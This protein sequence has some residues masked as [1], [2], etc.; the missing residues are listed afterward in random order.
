MF[1]VIAT[2][3]IPVPTVDDDMAENYYLFPRYINSTVP[4]EY[5][6]IGHNRADN[7]V[8]LTHNTLFDHGTAVSLHL[9]DD[10][11]DYQNTT[12]RTVYAII[13]VNA[14]TDS[15]GRAYK[16]YSA[17]TTD[18]IVGATEVYDSTEWRT[19]TNNFDSSADRWTSVLVPIQNTHYIVVENTSG[20]TSRRLQ[21]VVSNED[22]GLVVEPAA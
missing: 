7:L 10:T 2:Y 14:A 11:T 13:T 12:G 19:N 5:Q 15:G 22:A 18:S 3:T 17:P 20:V 16:I 4:L 1:P 21:L 8:K 6:R 9:T